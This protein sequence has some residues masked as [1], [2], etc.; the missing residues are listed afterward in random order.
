MKLGFPVGFGKGQR[1]WVGVC[2]EPPAASLMLDRGKFSP[3]GSHGAGWDSLRE[4]R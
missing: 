3:P 2:G 1:D 4:T